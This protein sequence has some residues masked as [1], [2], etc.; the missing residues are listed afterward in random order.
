MP[1][2]EPFLRDILQAY[3]QSITKLLRRIYIRAPKE[4]GLPDDKVLEVIKPLYGIPESGLH[5]FLTYSTQHIES[6]HMRQST[7]NPCLFYNRDDEGLHGIILP[8]FDDSLSFR[9]IS[10]VD[11]EERESVDFKSKP[12]T[13]LNHEPSHFNG[14]TIRHYKT[15]HTPPT[16]TSTTPF[17][18]KLPPTNQGTHREQ[19]DSA[20]DL[21]VASPGP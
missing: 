20:A 12:R 2:L 19:T 13:M 3:I 15:S 11:D 1:Y 21:I 10:F 4:L 9:N 8:Q 18:A 14:I 17:D 5:L 6:L 7:I 16:H